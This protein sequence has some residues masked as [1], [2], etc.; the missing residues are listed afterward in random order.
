MQVVISHRLLF[1]LAEKLAEQ[2]ER[3]EATNSIRAGR[4]AMAVSAALSSAACTMLAT[5]VFRVSVEVEDERREGD[6]NDAG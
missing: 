1:A 6:A 4:A 2:A 5:G 3:T